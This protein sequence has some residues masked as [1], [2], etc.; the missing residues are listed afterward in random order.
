LI[1]SRASPEML[2]LSWAAAGKLTAATPAAAMTAMMLERI[3]PSRLR[4]VGVPGGVQPGN[5]PDPAFA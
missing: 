1:S 2:T 5:H 4:V 3:G